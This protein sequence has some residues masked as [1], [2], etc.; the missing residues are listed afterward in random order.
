MKTISLLFAKL[1]VAISLVGLLCLALL[2]PHAR[3]QDPADSPSYSNDSS[4]TMDQNAPPPPDGQSAPDPNA[5][6]PPSRVARISFLDGTVS[7]QP[8]GQGEWGSAA[9]NRPVTVGDKLWTDQASR[10]ELQIG[11]ASIHVG[12]MTALSFLNLD[13]NVM[14]VRIPEGAINFRVRELREGDV[15]EVDTP[16]LAF[17]VRQAGAFRVNVSE[18]GDATTIVAIRGEGEVTTA[19]KTYTVHAGEQT[20]FEGTDNPQVHESA[21]P[22]PDG[23]DRWAAERDLRDDNST[24]AKYVSPDVPGVSDLDDNG[25]WNEEPDYGPVWYPAQVAPGWAPY[26]YGYWNYVGPWGWTWIGY[27][28]WGFAPYHYGRWAYIHSRW[29]WCPGP[30]YARPFYGPAFVGW[31]GGARFGVGFGFGAGLGV[32]WFPLGYREPWY[33]GFHA[34]RVYITNVN[35]HNTVIHNTTIL[36]TRNFNNYAYARN[37][38]AVTAASRSQ[39]VG[40]QAINR[41][42]Y[43]IN[44]A[45][46]RGA[47]VMNHNSFTPT[48]ASTFGAAHMHARAVPP[49]IIQNR[50]VMAR[51]TPSA[52]AGRQP[53]QRMSGNFTPGRASNFT[54]P[55]RTNGT[56]AN[57]GP[58][59]GFTG[60]NN[61]PRTAQPM[62]PR[63]N[64]QVSPNRPPQSMNN[65]PQATNNPAYNNRVGTNRRSWEAQGNSTDRGYAP[66]GFGSNNRYNNGAVNGGTTRARM[67]RPSWAGANPGGV[68][69]RGNAPVEP[70]RGSYE[71]RGGGY[72]GRGN[73]T[74]GRSNA[75]PSRSY[76]APRSN[77]PQSRSYSEPTRSYS[78]PSRS[79]SPPSRSYSPPART[80]A[81]A[82]PRSTGG[83]A[84]RS[85][86]GGFHGGGGGGGG[87]HGGGG[88]PHGGGRH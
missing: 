23:L 42:A 34:S 57:R 3:A 69:G 12:S 55:A 82:A 59:G 1:S 24:S 13:G 84:P 86:G 41:S 67:D 54:A 30:I 76:S 87:S 71:S 9:Q 35:I 78:A 44:N 31:L 36:N 58:Q 64:Q 51:T 16:N 28:P 38:R 14:Q 11:A 5:P 43:R 46:L 74:M 75:G 85:S 65:R 79:Y 37:T 62:A 21:A 81:P 22:G 50:P 10:A 18:N 63:T 68:N 17:T 66:Q 40:G 19:G 2:S 25:T 77:Y 53:F 48:R 56:F 20:E 26:S 27:E 72:A 80:S 8:G 60:N 33:P 52:A 49:N 45:S 4:A 29:G 32:G 88:G 83:G 73:E 6:D 15:Y 61:A 7:F 47:E 70:S 39:F